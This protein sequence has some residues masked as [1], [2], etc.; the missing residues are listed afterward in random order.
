MPPMN[1]K[2]SKVK[3]YCQDNPR[4]YPFHFEEMLGVKEDTAKKIYSAYRKKTGDTRHNYI[5]SANFYHY[6]F[7]EPLYRTDKTLTLDWN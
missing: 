1:I 5:P 7:N 4:L 6:L 2:K 3:K